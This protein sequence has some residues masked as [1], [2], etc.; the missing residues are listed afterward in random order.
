MLSS[1][2]NR[3]NVWAA[4]VAG[5]ALALAFLAFLPMAETRPVFLFVV[6][7]GCILLLVITLDPRM[8]AALL[9]FARVC[10]DPV[11]DLTR[12]ERGGIG[13]GAAVNV[14]VV[15]F[16]AILVI[17]NARYLRGNPLTGR[18][19]F[20]LAV[21]AASVLWSP[22]PFTSARLLFTLLSYF[23]MAVL[24]F[25]I[26]PL[27]ND[28][29]SWI[30]VLLASSVAPVLFANLDL[31]R[32]GHTFEDAGA[33]IAGT[34]THP[35]I[36]AFYLVF[37]IAL[38]FYVLRTGGP[39]LGGVKRFALLLYMADL[40]ALLLATKTRNAWI[41]CWA[42]FFVYGLLKERKYLVIAALAGVAALA[43][44]QV[45]SRA[46]ELQTVGGPRTNSFAWRVELWKSALPWIRDRFL[47]GYGLGT[48]QDLSR[49]F[50][51]LE[52]VAGVDAHNTYVQTVFETGVIGLAA[53]LLIYW[54]ILGVFFSRVKGATASVSIEYAIVVSYLVTYLFSS[55]ADNM[56][57]YLTLNWYVW[58][59]LGTML[60][61][62]R[63]HENFGFRNKPLV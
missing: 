19:T 42:F 4:A 60:K 13:A 16:T 36:L 39:A 34:F 47:F 2:A 14:F 10:L 25:V 37:A 56:F 15:L 5:A 35:N 21:C 3:F 26:E 49:N 20:F 24:P 57:Y 53:Y 31:L 44:P 7:L 43:L 63:F 1:S 50:F 61:A 28:K 11:L 40:F 41:S 18:W 33:R 46:Q 29:R 32:G 59:F 9:L 45:A 12:A 17:R 8:M 30:R 48:F 6:P 27:R 55:F 58:F 62:A 54:K 51:R 38:V 23:C 22:M 52:R